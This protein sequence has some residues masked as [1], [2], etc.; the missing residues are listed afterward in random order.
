M[1]KLNKMIINYLVIFFS[2][3]G[4]LLPGSVPPASAFNLGDILKDLEVKEQ[5]PQEKPPEKKEEQEQEQPKQPPQ[6]EPQGGLLGLGRALGIDK[7]TIDLIGKGVKTVQALQP[8]KYEEEKALGGAIAAQVFSRFGGS[9]DDKGLLQYINLIGNSVAMFSDRSEIEYHFAI[10]NNP[11]P[12]AFA[13]PGGYIFIT[14]GLLKKIKNEAELAG[15]LGHEIAHISQKHTLKTLQR[16]RSLQGIS[17]LTLSIM[18][19]N[20]EMFKNIIND[21]SNTLF[22]KG[23]DQNLEYEADR[24]GTEYASRVGYNPRGLTDFLKTL[25]KSQG[26]ER[27]IFFKTHPSPSNRIN[28]LMSTVLPGYK[29]TGKY[30][31]LSLRFKI[32]TKGKL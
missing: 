13:A 2:L 10:L 9:Y 18:D 1:R 19:K 23:L 31:K 12:N 5:K 26:K 25:K 29:G 3:I 6:K 22:E 17:N 8:I 11:E 15:V 27:S 14:T 28:Q 21:I 32:E 4:F 7:K 16:S 24:I 20:P 30:P